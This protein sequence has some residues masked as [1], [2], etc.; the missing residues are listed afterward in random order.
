[1]IYSVQLSGM[2]PAQETA[3]FIFSDFKHETDYYNNTMPYMEDL[4]TEHCINL[5]MT[6]KYQIFLVTLY[7]PSVSLVALRSVAPQPIF[8]IQTFFQPPLDLVLSSGVFSYSGFS[9]PLR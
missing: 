5:H 9:V 4:F 3:N 2:Y 6:R 8:Y 7:L 1:M